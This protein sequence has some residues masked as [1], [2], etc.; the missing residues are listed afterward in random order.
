MTYVGEVG[1]GAMIYIPSFIKICS[2]IKSWEG[3]YTDRQ[4]SDLIS[5]LLFFRSHENT[6]KIPAAWKVCTQTRVPSNPCLL[7]DTELL[8]IVIRSAAHGV[9]RGSLKMHNNQF[10]QRAFT[11]SFWNVCARIWE[12]VN[13]VLNYKAYN[14]ITNYVQSHDLK[15]L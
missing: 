9:E 10:L 11:I 14:V 4:Q 1:S 7:V 12:T 8:K 3:G 15:M 5:L 2:G 13:S 6:L